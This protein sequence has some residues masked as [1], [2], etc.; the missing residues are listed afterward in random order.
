[1]GAIKDLTGKQF[2]RLFVLEYI[3][4][5]RQKQARWLCSCVCGNQVQVDGRAMRRGATRSCGCFKRERAIETF[6]THGE[7]DSIAY[8]TWVDM[9]ARC[10]NTEAKAYKD[11]GG[12]GITVCERWK[13]FP[14]FLQDMGQAPAGK[15]IERINNNGDYSPD[16][17][18]WAS[19]KEQSRNKRSNRFLTH[20]GLTL[21][22]SD[23]ALRLGLGSTLSGRINAGWSLEKA[24]SSCR[25]RSNGMTYERKEL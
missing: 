24:L 13:S 20:G 22:V 1:M 16:N 17:C 5:G 4:I 25:Y 21:C 3:G 11:Y 10:F 9:K 12:R 7:H 18:R 2:D 15:S 14:L 6:K 23:W 8:T 19:P